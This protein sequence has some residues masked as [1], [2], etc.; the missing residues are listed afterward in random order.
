MQ[1]PCDQRGEAMFKNDQHDRVG[2]DMSKISYLSI[3]QRAAE[4]GVK[5][6]TFVIGVALQNPDA[7]I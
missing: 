7:T 6:T 4:V 3:R 5:S 2:I 1:W